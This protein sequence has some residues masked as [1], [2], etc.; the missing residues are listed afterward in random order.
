ML[1]LIFCC[2]YDIIS[3]TVN[4]K[5]YIYKDQCEQNEDKRWSYELIYCLVYEHLIFML[6]PLF[7]FSKYVSKSLLGAQFQVMGQNY[8]CPENEYYFPICKSVFIFY[9]LNILDAV[10]N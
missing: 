10:I 6:Q 2:L 5:I 1:S 9:H 4:L 3:F 8:I 7:N